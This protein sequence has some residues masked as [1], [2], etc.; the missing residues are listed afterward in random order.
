M[1]NLSSD[2]K[3]Y[4]GA[5]ANVICNCE[6]AFNNKEGRKSI[7]ETLEN[8]GEENLKILKRKYKN[9]FEFLDDKEMIDEFNKVKSKEDIEK[10]IKQIVEKIKLDE[11]NT[12]TKKDKKEIKTSI[13]VK[14]ALLILSSHEVKAMKNDRDDIERFLNT[15]KDVIEKEYKSFSKIESEDDVFKNLKNSP[16]AE[17]FERIFIRFFNRKFSKKLKKVN[18]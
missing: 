14:K 17:G 12:K 18:L 11:K 3:R 10:K 7:V 15:N 13:Y 16:N 6:N 2:L 5:I 1:A 4:A 8:I 9:S